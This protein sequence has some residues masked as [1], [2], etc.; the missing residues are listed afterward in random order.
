MQV[1]EI[2][3][4]NRVIFGDKVKI[5]EKNIAFGD[6]RDNIL[7]L[8]DE[9]DL[10]DSVIKFKGNSSIAFLSSN[11]HRYNMRATVYNNSAL[12]MGED[13]YINTGGE[14]FQL[15]LSEQKHFVMGSYCNLSFNIWVRNADAHLI[16]STETKERLNPTKSIYVGDHVWLGQSVILL[17]GTQIGSGSIVGAGAV[18]SGKKIP[19]NTSWAGNPARQIKDKIFWTSLF[20]H[21]WTARETEYY[22]KFETDAVTYE[23]DADSLSFD[24]IEQRLNACRTADDKLKFLLELSENQSKNRFAVA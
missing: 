11:T 12:F 4:G 24:V 15:I 2:I 3:N 19:S 1:Y 21:N 10:G 7:Y 20:V 23:C 13:N 6:G 22:K 5:N 14:P 18:V 17:K 9:V 16:Y 8:A